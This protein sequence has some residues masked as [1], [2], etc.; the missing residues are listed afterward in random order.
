VDAPGTDADP[1]GL[2][3]M[4]G[5]WFQTAYDEPRRVLGLPA[6]ITGGQD[7]VICIVDQVVRG[8]GIVGRV[9]GDFGAVAVKLPGVGRPVQ[10]RVD[11]QLDDLSTRWWSDRVRP[12]RNEP[13]RPRVVLL[14]VQGTIRGAAVLAR[15]QGW[16]GAASAHA[17]LDFTLAADEI[18]G[19]LVVEVAEAELPPWSAR[20]VSARSALGLRIDTILVRE[21][22]P[23]TA[24]A[25]SRTG[26][27][28]AVLQPG[29]PADFRLEIS[30]AALAPPVPR[31]P[32]TP[33]TKRKPSRAAFK[34]LR[35]ARRAAVRARSETLPDRPDSGIGVLA[36]DL[37][38]GVPIAVEI[39]SRRTGSLDLRLAAPPEGPVL[40]GLD[41]AHPGLSCR[42]VPI[43]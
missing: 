26:C 23:T 21:T 8:T 3:G 30:T 6:E 42:I 17:T 20:R 12:P 24:P 27:D 38:S 43:R 28:L 19:L 31:S 2:V 29:D 41:R 15:R 13:E 39:V 22:D 37:G 7:D 33:L 40:I 36:A 1:H 25:P 9:T 32:V 5:T 14:R 34:A 4:I 16:R 11:L 35:I 18:D 10:V